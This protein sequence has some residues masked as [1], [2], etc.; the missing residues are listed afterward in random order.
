M[1]PDR[2][3]ELI[4]LAALG[5]LSDAERAE[6]DAV[7]AIDPVARVELDAALAAAADVQ[8][9]VAEP[10]PVS[11]RASVLAAISSTAQDHDD[12]TPPSAPEPTSGAE[13]SS[14]AGPAAVRDADIDLAAVVD[15]GGRRRRRLL[16]WA[17]AAAA[18]VVFVVGAFIVSNEASAPDQFEAIV[19]APDA[20]S[21]SMEGDL[22]GVLTVT[23]SPSHSALVLES[24]GIAPLPDDATY[25][26]WADID[27]EMVSVGVFRP[28]AGGRVQA[29]LD[30]VDTTGE[31]L[32]ITAEPAGGSPEPTLPVLASA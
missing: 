23:Y 17:L 10:P 15:L 18:V 31:S 28:D 5:E 3:D 24:D 16:P 2:L 20:V 22:G 7:V 30:E 8:Q 21:H 1:E 11:L 9:L 6:L 13:P 27:G 26:L 19:E 14:G 25:Q 29:R 32:N 4:A 12:V